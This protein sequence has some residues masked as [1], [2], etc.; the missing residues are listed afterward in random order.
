MELKP[1]Y[2][3]RHIGISFSYNC[4]NMELKLIDSTTSSTFSGAYNCTNMEL[5]RDIAT[6]ALV[7]GLLIIAPIWN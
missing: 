5:K 2:L 6:Q 3:N 4:T 7:D 1:G